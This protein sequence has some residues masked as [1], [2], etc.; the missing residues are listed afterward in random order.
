MKTT[1]IICPD[2]TA[3]MVP[4]NAADAMIKR[5]AWRN[6]TGCFVIAHMVA[7]RGERSPCSS[8]AE[9]ATYNCVMKVRLFP[10]GPWAGD[11]TG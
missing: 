3:N 4:K 7:L 11:G 2:V 1:A 6:L 8:M 10:R 5:W 9:R